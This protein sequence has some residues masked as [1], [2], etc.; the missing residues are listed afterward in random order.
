[1]SPNTLILHLVGPP[2]NDNAGYCFKMLIGTDDS[3]MYYYHQQLIDKA[4]P[5]GLLPADLKR[6]GKT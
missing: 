3:E 2:E 1:K 6:M 4:N 5:R